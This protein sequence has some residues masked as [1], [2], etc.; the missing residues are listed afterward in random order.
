MS[1]KIYD[2][3]SVWIIIF[4]VLSKQK[5]V[6][7]TLRTRHCHIFLLIIRIDIKEMLFCSHAVRV[8]KKSHDFQP[9]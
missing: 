9:C 5:V 3:V 1:P 2:R 7:K 6:H 4:R 8:K